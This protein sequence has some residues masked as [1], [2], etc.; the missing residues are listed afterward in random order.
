[1]QHT[2]AVVVFLWVPSHYKHEWLISSDHRLQVMVQIHLCIDHPGIP[3]HHRTVKASMQSENYSLSCY[4]TSEIQCCF[5]IVLFVWKS[6]CLLFIFLLFPMCMYSFLFIL[7][8][9]ELVFIVLGYFLYSLD[10]KW[11]HVC[12]NL[13]VLRPFVAYVFHMFFLCS[14][15]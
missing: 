2:S 12:R 11:R 5:L 8:L 15:Y 6:G 10:E 3:H 7:Q 1:M 4:S 13:R 9:Y 14:F